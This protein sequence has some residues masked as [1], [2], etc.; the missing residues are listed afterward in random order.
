MN[1]TRS[2]AWVIPEVI[3][4]RMS[5]GN[6]SERCQSSSTRLDKFWKEE[7]RHVDA[8]KDLESKG[9]WVL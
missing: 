6:S 3:K 2:V 1:F 7:G 4:V 5:T 8:K 9:A